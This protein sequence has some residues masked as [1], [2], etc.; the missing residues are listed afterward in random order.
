MTKS[1]QISEDYP[2]NIETLWNDI[3][4]PQALADSMKG[5]VTYIGLPSEPVFEGQVVNIRL[6]YWGWLP[7]GAWRIEVTR[8]DNENYILET[9]EG[10]GVFKSYH[11]RLE[12]VATGDESCRYTDNL[13]VDAGIFTPLAAPNVP[14]IYRER[15]RQRRARLVAAAS[16]P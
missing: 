14:S 5:R 3:L 4:D 6:K 10:G 2:V 7:L 1:Y 16:A 8:V 9:R 11:H 13:T 15:H 12:L